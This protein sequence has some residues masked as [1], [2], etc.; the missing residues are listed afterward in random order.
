MNTRFDYKYRDGGNYKTFY[1]FVFE[2]EISKE[3]LKHFEDICY[4]EMF[5][6]RALGLPGGVFPGD[7]GYDAELD[8][9][10]CEHNFEDSF[11]LVSDMPSVI[12]VN[13]KTGIVGIDEFLK[14][15]EECSENWENA[16]SN[17]VKLLEYKTERQELSLADQ[18]QAAENF[19]TDMGVINVPLSKDELDLIK[20]SLDAFGDRLADREGYSSGEECWNLKE[21]IESFEKEHSQGVER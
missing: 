21:K 14:A 18:I 15:F 6:P 4:D 8:H 2:G 1:D 13:G 9:Y 10:W 11:R 17:P 3:Q 7:E 16:L 19:A 5:I 12:S 20:K